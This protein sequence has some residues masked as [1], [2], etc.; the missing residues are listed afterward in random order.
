MIDQ[1]LP[2]LVAHSA[3]CVS[4]IGKNWSIIN[5]TT[6][7]HQEW[8]FSGQIRQLPYVSD[9]HFSHTKNRTTKVHSLYFCSKPESAEYPQFNLEH[10]K[11]ARPLFDPED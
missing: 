1:F 5:E 8:V 6:F 3:P 11:P 4:E 10:S 2:N 7:G 9:R